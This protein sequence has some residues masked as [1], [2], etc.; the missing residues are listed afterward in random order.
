[1]LS[2]VLR[3]LCLLAALTAAAHPDGLVTD[4]KVRQSGDTVKIVIPANAA[5][6]HRARALDKSV[7]VDLFPAKLGSAAKSDYAVNCGLIS[8]VHVRQFNEST[9]RI[10]VDAI[11][12]PSFNLT[13]RPQSCGLAL[14]VSPFKTGRVRNNRAQRKLVTL[15]LVDADLSGVIKLLAKIMGR[16]L[17]LGP[18]VQGSVTAKFDG[19]PAEAAL[20]LVLGLQEFECAYRLVEPGT[21]V[22]AAPKAIQDIID[23]CGQNHHYRAIPKNSVWREFLLKQVQEP[24]VLSILESR[25]SRVRFTHHPTENGFFAHGSLLDLYGVRELVSELDVAPAQPPGPTREIVK[26]RYPNLLEIK[27]LITSMVSGLSC[28]I[29]EDNSGFIVE[30]SPDAI[31]LFR[32]TLAKILADRFYE[33]WL[34]VPQTEPSRSSSP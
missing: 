29:S 6:Q 15:D 12:A 31:A 10:T 4:V 9:V 24:K 7:V 16:N 30:G 25:F 14:D 5:V 23:D 19:V 34:S 13:E 33:N 32:E 21:I 20:K 1:M 26:L 8:K 17:Y 22:V 28:Q 11:S 2:R 27:E 3:S 18:G